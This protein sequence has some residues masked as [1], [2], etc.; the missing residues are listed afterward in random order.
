MKRYMA[1]CAVGL[2]ALSVVAQAQTS[3]LLG[4]MVAKASGSLV[5]VKYTVALETGNRTGAGQA[6]CISP[7]GVFLTTSLD[8]RMRVEE[9]KDFELVLP[10]NEGTTLKA[11]LLGIDPW[12]GLGF[13]QC[14]EKHEWQ[15]VQFSRTS[16]VKLGD[17]VMS[18]GLMMSDPSWP[19][20]VGTAYV[21]S[22]LRVP[23]DLIFVNGG[24]LTGSC[25]PVFNAGGQ[26][27]GIIGRQ[28]PL[29][30]EAPTEKGMAPL[31]LVDQQQ[32]AFFTPVEEFVHILENIPS[33]GK[34]ARL[35]WL[36][37]NKFEA[38][39]KDL[40][41]ILKLDKPGVKIDEVIPGQP[42]KKA[43]LADRDIIVEM[44]GKPLEKL[45]TPDLTVKNFVR[46][47]MRMRVGTVVKLKVLGVSGTAS[48]EVNVTLEEMPVRPNEAKQ[49]F[50]KAI[51]LLIREKVPLDEYLDKTGSSTVPGLIVVGMVKDSPVAIAGLQGADV[52]TNVNNQPVKTADTFK[53]IVE[54][55]LASG[56]TQ[57]IQMLIRRGDKAEVI[58]VRPTTSE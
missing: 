34:V 46:Q 11:K 21:S 10:G 1:F 20:Y 49:Y 29:G 53:E 32:A 27:I 42:G 47:L 38:V 5:V 56:P 48:R 54:K 9:L 25:S 35:P 57:P 16:Q 8:P 40:A 31:Q 24:R 12:T 3:K 14:T 7:A 6:V 58:T 44:D 15:V 41:L 2:L 43:G 26:A 19:V 4:D 39:D 30:Y 50:N 17:E 23:N 18:I 45:A 22:K 36:G 13:V 51:G 33:D 37:I 52:I 28:L 55:S